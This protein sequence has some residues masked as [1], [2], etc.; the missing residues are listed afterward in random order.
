M[1]NLLNK[2]E[3]ETLATYSATSD[4]AEKTLAKLILQLRAD[5]YLSTDYR[6]PIS[7]KYSATCTPEQYAE[8]KDALANG[9][10]KAAYML[11][12]SSRAEAKAFDDAK[13]AKKRAIIQ[14]VGT[15]I[16]R[17]ANKLFKLENPGNDEKAP[18][19]PVS[20]EV[21]MREAINKC[22]KIAEKTEAPIYDVVAFTKALNDAQRIP[23]VRISK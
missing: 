2:N 17:V 23:S 20:D 9:L 5:G 10:G 16:D 21:K 1:T 11:F 22:L 6:S 15:Y 8:R 7:K 12:T 4:K 13:K 14:D 19:V 3:T 18:S